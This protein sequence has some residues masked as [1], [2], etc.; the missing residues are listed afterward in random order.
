[1]GEILDSLAEAGAGFIWAIMLVAF[2]ALTIFVAYRFY[3]ATISTIYVVS[4]IVIL[5]LFLTP[6][7]SVF[8]YLGNLLGSALTLSSVFT[9][10]GALIGLIVGVYLWAHFH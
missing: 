2:V 9:A 8:A 1:M 6:C 5:G 4:E 7:T 10:V 3:K